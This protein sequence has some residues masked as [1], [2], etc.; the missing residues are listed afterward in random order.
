MDL[1]QLKKEL[2]KDSEFKSFYENPDLAFKISEMVI[3]LR[4]KKGL[5][6]KALAKKIETNQSSIARLESGKTLPSLSF[7]EKIAKACETELT[8]PKFSCLEKESHTP[9]III[10]SDD[11]NK[12]SVS[13]NN[14]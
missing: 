10:N 1:N 13:L 12:Q 2:M 3:N 8:P 4:I 6:Q 9:L 11:S 5:T 7:L 14:Y